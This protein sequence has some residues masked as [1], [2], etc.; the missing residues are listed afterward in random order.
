MEWSMEK[1]SR[2]RVNFFGVRVTSVCLLALALSMGIEIGVL[3]KSR[4]GRTNAPSLNALANS[5]S[6]TVAKR[7]SL[8]EGKGSNAP[9]FTCTWTGS[10]NTDWSTAGNW[11]GCNSTVPQAGDTVSIGGAAN[12]PTLAA[13]APSSGNL[14]TVAI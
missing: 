10:V 12:Q 13:T 6:G 3:A 11:S 14:G 9:L 1:S 8:S 4:P 7:D 5:F 2:A